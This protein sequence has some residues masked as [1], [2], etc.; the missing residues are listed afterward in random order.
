MGTAFICLILVI[1]AVLSV[2]SY[3]K[4]LTHGC[5]GGGDVAEKKVKVQDKKKEH[6][7][8]HK[9]IEVDGMTCKNCAL[10]IENAFNSQQGCYGIVNLKEKQADLYMKQ[11]SSD[12]EIK[13]LIEKV[14]YNV[15][16]IET[17]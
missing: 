5:C 6:Y 1:I 2:K 7:P 17:L 15:N 11:L 12:E 14:G 8:Y 10:K 13:S 4:K 16:K 3:M 9:K